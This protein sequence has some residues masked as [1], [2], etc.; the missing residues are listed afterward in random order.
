MRIYGDHLK[1][2]E[3]T[4]RLG[5]VPSES[6]QNGDL[7]RLKKSASVGGWF[8]SSQGNVESRDVQRHILW[9]LDQL[10]DREALLKAL[11]DEGHEIDVFCFWVSAHG[12]GGPELSPEIMQRLSSMSLKIGF[13]V[14]C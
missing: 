4:L 10:I 5:L 11:Q 1:P 3:I 7:T 6:Q 14:Y 13:D 8:M 12:H 2:G 9:I